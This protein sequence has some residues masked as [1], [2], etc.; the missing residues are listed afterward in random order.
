MASLCELTSSSMR[1][2]LSFKEQDMEGRSLSSRKLALLFCQV[3]KSCSCWHLRT[4]PWRHHLLLSGLSR[5]GEDRLELVMSSLH[6]C[7]CAINSS[8]DLHPM[9]RPHHPGKTLKKRGQPI[10][11]LRLLHFMGPPTA[12][13]P[14]TARPL[15]CALRSSNATH[16]A[17][18]LIDR[19]VFQWRSRPRGAVNEENT[20]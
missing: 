13:P 1:S 16:F 18:L 10:Q 17:R 2:M 11:V 15:N 7:E 5:C 9:S 12:Q 14:T 8:T 4:L 19:L 3:A 20:R 6:L